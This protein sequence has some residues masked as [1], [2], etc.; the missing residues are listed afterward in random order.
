MKIL[1]TGANGL[2]GS[3][4]IRELL[5]HNHKITALVEH[6]KAPTTIEGLAIDIKYG[7]ILN[8]DQLTIQM[9][10]MDAVIHCAA[11]A[12]VWPAKSEAFY[13]VNVEGTKNVIN[14]CLNNKIQR[15]IFVGTANSFGSGQKRKP[16]N[17]NEP[18]RA[19]VYGLDYM[20]SKR[21]AQ[22]LIL[23]AVKTKGLPAIIVNPTFMI[24]PYDS[25]PSSG[26]MI[27]ALYHGKVP[28]FTKG[29]KNYIN[30]KDAA[31]GISNALTLGR[32][33]ECYILGNENL[34][35]K[36][37]FHKIG[38]VIGKKAPKRSLPISLVKAYG[39]L[40]SMLANA[41][42]YT[43][44]VSYEMAVLSCE[45]HYYSAQKAIDEL[46]LPQTP[47][48]NG[49]LDCYEWFKNNGYLNA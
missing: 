1:V 18:Y 35:F 6:G 37:M 34:T 39:K 30:V 11:Y 7:D 15:A 28:C 36:E 47:I 41:F 2:L 40:N 3:N 19:G 17:E 27:H 32:I 29:G 23:E 16:G 31:V 48:E 20:D 5:K 49:V 42:N 21:E 44:A 12:S 46:Q 8:P 14:A 45:D 26:A 4:V 24:G 38:T 9:Q 10:G 25:K 22:E 43:P 33:G 13:K